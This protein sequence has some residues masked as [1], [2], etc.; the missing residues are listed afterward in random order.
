MWPAL[1]AAVADL[2]HLLGRGYAEIAALELVGNRHQ[3]TVRQ[4]MAVR[5]CACTDAQRSGRMARCVGPERWR[6]AALAVDGFNVLTTVEVALAGGVLLRARDSCVRDI[7]SMH[8]SFRRVDET[9]PALQH[10]A[11]VLIAAR[12]TSVLWILDRPVGNSGR[13]A[14][15]I[16]DV[17]ATRELAWTVELHD[18]ADAALRSA[19]VL[20]A[21]ADSAIL[22]AIGPWIDL[23]SV[24]IAR[25]AAAP[26]V[27]LASE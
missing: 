23:A 13:L 26:I 17:A 6:G 3:L 8:G 2:S 5:R 16:R 27:D 20:V 11:D 19:P 18:R 25:L 9:E 14:Q 7:A 12:P 22:D 15:R 1:R 10:L 4:R 21:T 24:A